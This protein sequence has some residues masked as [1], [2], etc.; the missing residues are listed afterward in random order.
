MG[1]WLRHLAW[2]LGRDA[3]DGGGGGAGEGCGGASANGGGGGDW[4]AAVLV[5]PAHVIVMV[6][7]GVS[8][9]T[10]WAARAGKSGLAQQGPGHLPGPMWA[11]CRAEVRLPAGHSWARIAHS[12]DYYENNFT[13][14]GTHMSSFLQ[15]PL[16]KDDSFSA[17]YSA[18]YLG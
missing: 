5:V 11:T 2:G 8:D 18:L 4:V 15:F 10:A 16:Y 14:P 13:S 9:S 7:L 12:G 3:W 6:P 17:P 1:P